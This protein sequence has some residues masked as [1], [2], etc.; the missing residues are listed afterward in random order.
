MGFFFNNL[1]AHRVKDL[2]SE[3]KYEDGY[4]ESYALL[5]LIEKGDIISHITE[6]KLKRI[7][8]SYKKIKEE[9]NTSNH[10]RLNAILGQKPEITRWINEALDALKNE[11]IAI[12]R[13]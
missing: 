8:L 13:P 2:F 1:Q 12:A 6:E 3:L 10:A 4:Q 9:R 5:E 7:K 11:G